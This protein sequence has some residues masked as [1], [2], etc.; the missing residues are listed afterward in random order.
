[1]RVDTRTIEKWI[2][3]AHE[4]MNLKDKHR[5]GRPSVLSVWEKGLIAASARVHPRQSTPPQLCL[6]LDLDCSPRTVRRTL[7]DANLRAH[8]ARHLYPLSPVQIQRRLSFAQGYGGWT[9]QQWDVVLFGDETTFATINYFTVW[10]QS[11]PNTSY[12]PEHI[13]A[14]LPHP[15]KV[16][17]WGCISSAGVGTLYTFKETLD[18]SL[19][20]SIYDTCLLESAEKLFH[21][22]RQWYFLH[23]NDPKHTDGRVKEWLH[24]NGV[25][26]MDFPT[27][28]P[29]LNP[30]EN[31][32]SEMKRRVN[33]HRCPDS[34]TLQDAI[35][36]EWLKIDV[37]YLRRLV[38][39]MPKRC[40][41]VVAAH[42][43]RVHY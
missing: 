24:R 35:H 20:R 43:F 36:E 32:W 22:P 26:T 3:R 12:A 1:M 30:I 25:T 42:G 10:V 18:G 14:H 41:K 29:D 19:M 23:D 13:A 37:T 34:D 38:H 21:L 16:H 33:E 40:E 31:V 8:H 27:Y 6:E 4:S 2:E 17:A 9:K 7:D 11:E 39:S 5:S 15:P 28:S